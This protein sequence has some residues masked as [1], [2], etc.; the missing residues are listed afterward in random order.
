MR[1]PNPYPKCE[2]AFYP[3]DLGSAGW[4]MDALDGPWDGH[5]TPHC[6]KRGTSRETIALDVPRVPTV[7]W[8]ASYTPPQIDVPGRLIENFLGNV[9]CVDYGICCSIGRP[10]SCK[11][12]TYPEMTNR[13][14]SM[15]NFARA[16]CYSAILLCLTIRAK[17]AIPHMR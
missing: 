8:S 15:R 7:F 12:L 17:R 13:K 6:A 9:L 14:C 10:R 1:N 4:P 11:C 5:G 3:C 2:K 16:C